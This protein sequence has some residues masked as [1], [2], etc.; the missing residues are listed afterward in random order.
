VFTVESSSSFKM[1]LIGLR[2]L[3]LLKKENQRCY[4]HRGLG[5][6]S[7]MSSGYSRIDFHFRNSLDLEGKIGDGGRDAAVTLE[8]R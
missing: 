5:P 3:I 1:T 8:M 4:V 7:I 6:W 2:L